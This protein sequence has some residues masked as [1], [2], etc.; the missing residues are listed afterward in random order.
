MSEE[1]NHKENIIVEPN[2]KNN[3]L[4]ISADLKEGFLAWGLFEP[5]KIIAFK[6]CLSCHLI[7]L[8]IETDKW[9][10]ILKENKND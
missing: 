1:C 3:F 4:C 10:P 9:I 6:L 2:G 8:S 5:Q 7:W